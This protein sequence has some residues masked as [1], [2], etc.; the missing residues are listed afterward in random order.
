MSGRLHGRRSLVTGAATG[1]GRATSERLAAEGAEVVLFG[2]GGANS[3]RLPR[4][5]AASPSTET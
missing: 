4:A 1:I 2:L 3:K 5:S